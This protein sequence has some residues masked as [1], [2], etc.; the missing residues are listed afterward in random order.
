MMTDEQ[1]SRWERNRGAL[2]FVRLALGGALAW[3]VPTAC[4]YSA[5]MPIL[6]GSHIEFGPTLKV[7][8]ITFPIGGLVLF[9]PLMWFMGEARYH[10]WHQAKQRAQSHGG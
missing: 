10:R 6:G 4:M 2:G 3:G 5:V 9:G 8:L 1:A 7:A